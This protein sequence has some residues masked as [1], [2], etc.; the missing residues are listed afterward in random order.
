M[1]KPTF[2]TQLGMFG[3]AYARLMVHYFDW[4]SHF[5]EFEALAEDDRVILGNIFIQDIDLKLIGT[6]IH[7]PLIFSAFN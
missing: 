6:F 3:L 7:F 2:Q 4:A 5:D 1:G